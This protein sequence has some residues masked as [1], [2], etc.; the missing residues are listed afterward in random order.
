MFGATGARD[1]LASVARMGAGGFA[2]LCALSAAIFVPL[3]A[4]WLAALPGGTIRQLGLFSWARMV[5]EA[6][7]DILPF[8]QLGGI[9][10]GTRIVG[11]R[12]VPLPRLYASLVVD[13]TTEMAAQLIFSLFGLWIMAALLMDRGAAVALRPA[14]LGGTAVMIA[15]MLVFF[16]M[17]KPAL[18]LASRM[19]E[20]MLAGAAA[21]IGEIEATLAAVYARRWRVF[22]SFA[23]NLV[24]WTGT[25]AVGWLALRLM[26]HPIS[27]LDAVALESLIFTLRSVAFFVPGALGIQEAAYVLAGPLFGLPPDVALALSLAKR[28][29][30]LA[31]GV[32]ALLAWQATETRALYRHRRVEGAP[33]P[34]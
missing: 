9:V 13:M 11:S 34:Y 5:R 12:G 24:A 18:R 2:L 33:R 29:R 14:I 8:S 6:A 4:A 26:G 23:F 27:F 10:V 16:G 20:R 25:A 28:A 17:Q 31:L 22:A 19:A 3:G 30:D 32:P 1:I 21:S 15:V 7:A